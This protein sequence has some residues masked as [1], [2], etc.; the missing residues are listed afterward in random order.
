MKIIVL[1]SE[2]LHHAYF[3]KKLVE[4]FPVERV[5]VET[6]SI[7]PAFD[8][9]H[10][11]EEIRDEYERNEFFKGIK[12]RLSDDENTLIVDSVNDSKFISYLKRLSPDIIFV[13][14]TGKLNEELI[15]ICPHGIINFHGGDP[16]RYRGLDSHLWSIYNNDFDSF[17]VT[18]HKV[19]DRLDDGEILQQ[20]PIPLFRGMK[21]FQLRKYNTEVCI[22]LAYSALVDREKQ[23]GHFLFKPQ[24]KKGRY[25]SFMPSDLKEICVR[26]F[27]KFTDELDEIHKNAQ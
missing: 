10:P 27:E 12:A 2:T 23:N 21:L 19:N 22:E 5:V 14:G 9:F 11:F 7:K 6:K 4:K 16:E 1:T 3:V 20:K 18:L 15:R 24:R 25:Y 26:S 13:F 8:T 17:I